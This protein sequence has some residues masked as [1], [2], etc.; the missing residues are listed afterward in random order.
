MTTHREYR[1][2]RIDD[3]RQFVGDERIRQKAIQ[4]HSHY[5]WIEVSIG[6]GSLAP[7]DKTVTKTMGTAGR[8]VKS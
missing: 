1:T 4:L 8:P 7:P 6:R 5:N 3:F 2:T